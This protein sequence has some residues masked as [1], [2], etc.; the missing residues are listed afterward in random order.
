MKDGNSIAEWR[1]VPKSLKVMTRGGG[2]GLLDKKEG[3]DILEVKSLIPKSTCIDIEQTENEIIFDVLEGNIDLNHIGGILS[4][5]K[6]GTGNV[7]FPSG[8]L[9]MGNGANELVATKLAPRGAVVGT[10]DAQTLE[11]KVIK[12]SAG[13]IVTATFLRSAKDD[14]LIGEEYPPEVGYIFKI[15][16]PGVAGWRPI[17]DDNP[18]VQKYQALFKPTVAAV[19]ALKSENQALK[20]AISKLGMHI[21][22]LIEEVETLKVRIGGNGSSG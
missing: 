21:T 22:N 17:S 12:A 8:C 18:E 16:E 20:M 19:E 6:G 10:N 13:N 15:V 11:H 7:S 5:E 4:V 1:P 2:I 3:S 9:L 14:V